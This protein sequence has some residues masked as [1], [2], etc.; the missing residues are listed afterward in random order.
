MEHTTVMKTKTINLYQFDE[1]DDLSKQVAREWYRSAC[2]G[3]TYW[4]ESVIDECTTI[5]QHLGI[6]KPIF[7][8]SGFSSQGDGACVVGQWYASDYNGKELE[9][10]QDKKLQNIKAGFADFVKRFPHSSF[11]STSRDNYA[12][13]RVCLGQDDEE[14][15]LVDDDAEEE[16]KELVRDFGNYVYRALEAEYEYVNADEQVDEN[17][18]ANEYDFTIDGK[19]A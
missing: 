6:P 8:W 17:I 11:T 10:Y 3:D 16:M 1:L 19:R 15:D 18:R 2:D 4:S 14:C 7:Y 12:S 5:A 13:V 9:Q